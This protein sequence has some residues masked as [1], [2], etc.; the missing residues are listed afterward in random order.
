MNKVVYVVFKK[1]KYDNRKELH[2]IFYKA[3]EAICECR[4][5]EIENE[6]YDTFMEEVTVE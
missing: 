1:H 2:K 4:Y 5:F 3:D 6:D